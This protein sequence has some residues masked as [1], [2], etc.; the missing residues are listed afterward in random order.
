MKLEI[1]TA[2]N[3]ETVALCDMPP[4]NLLAPFRKL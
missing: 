1:L 3:I 4:Y 2:L